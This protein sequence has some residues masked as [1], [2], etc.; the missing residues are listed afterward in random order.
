[1]RFPKHFTRLKGAGL[2]PL[3]GS[4]T[5]PTN[6]D[7][8]FR[9]P[10]TNDDNVY[11][12]KAVST[13]G[14][15]LTRVVVHGTYTGSTTVPAALVISVYVFEDRLN[16]WIKL[17][18]SAASLVPSTPAATV[19]AATTPVYFDAVSLIDLPHRL[20]DDDSPSSGAAA[21]LVLVADPGAGAPDGTYTFV[22]GG[23]LSAKAF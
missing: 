8:T 5:F 12:T 10:S 20:A 2:T 14:W 7:G 1:M 3:L 13:N 4:D 17:P 22:V 21:F 18:Q 23:E 9:R 6:T 16:F 19:P 15:P 11:F